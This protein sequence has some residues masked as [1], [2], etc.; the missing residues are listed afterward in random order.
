MKRFLPIFLAFL[1][2]VPAAY[3]AEAET[4]AQDRYVTSAWAQETVAKAVDLGLAQAPYSSDGRTPITRGNFGTNASALVAL[5]FG[6]DF[7]TYSAAQSFQAQ[8][9]EADLLPIATQL[10]ILQ[11]KENGNLDLDGRITRQEAAVM[12]ARAYRSYSTQEVPAMEPLTYADRADIADWALTDVQL[13]KHLGIMN[14]EEDNCF[15]PNENYTVEQCLVTL[16]RLYEQTFQEDPPD[17]DNPF[18][19]TP[20]EE[21][22]GSFWMTGYDLTSYTE[23]ENLVAFSWGKNAGTVSGPNYFVTVFD[24]DLNRWDYRSVILANS[25]AQYGDSDA[26]AENVTISE[27]GTKVFYQAK[28]EVDVYPY[29]EE[30]NQGPKLFEKGIYTVTIDLTTGKQT[31]TRED[32]R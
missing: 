25:T 2:L 3:A 17:L 18:V 7:Q 19:M 24:R 15:H 13:M 5:A 31:Y 12:L 22:I 21:A 29:D 30:G 26:Y 4:P 32:F 10:G 1:L 14:G 8:K 20:L 28:V 11:G 6:V 9:D 27:D 23:S 16:V